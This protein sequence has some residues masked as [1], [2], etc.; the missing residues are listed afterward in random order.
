MRARPLTRSSS[1]CCALYAILS[2]LSWLLALGFP[3]PGLFYRRV[4]LSCDTL[5]FRWLVKMTPLYMN[6]PHMRTTLNG[7]ISA[8]NLLIKS[9]S[10]PPILFQLTLSFPHTFSRWSSNAIQSLTSVKYLNTGKLR[11]SAQHYSVPYATLRG[12]LLG[13]LPKATAHSDH[14]RLSLVQEEHLS[15]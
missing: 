11:A 8:L 2:S 3:K 4:V 13:R 12:R 1:G 7:H 9:L 10:I 5:A 14:Q 15:K 6:H